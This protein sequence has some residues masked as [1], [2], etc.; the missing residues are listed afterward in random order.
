M[1]I[2]VCLPS[3]VVLFIWA[4]S[5]LQNAPKLFKSVLHSEFIPLFFS[6]NLQK[7]TNMHLS[8]GY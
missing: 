4:N 3:K 8:E 2:N 7:K 6:S 5:T 1:Y